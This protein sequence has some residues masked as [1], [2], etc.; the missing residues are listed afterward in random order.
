MYTAQAS[1]Y[2]LVKV[3]GLWYWCDS[4]KCRQLLLVNYLIEHW[5]KITWSAL[6][7]VLAVVLISFIIPEP[8][9]QNYVPVVSTQDSI[10]P[11]NEQTL[12]EEI[13][14]QGI[15]CEKEVLAQAKI[16]SLH[17]T[18]GLLSKTNNMF[19]MR[20]PGK[21]KTTAIGVY[22]QGKDSIIYG[23]PKELKKYLKLP[24]YAVYASWQDAV[25][26][27]KLWQ[28]FS[29]KTRSKYLDFLSSI[30]AEDSTYVMRVKQVA[31]KIDL[32]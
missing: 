9:N 4:L 11:L 14:K 12:F 22:L 29:F 21:R 20:Y 32:E 3:N 8:G 1:G 15:I 2:H 19:G 6:V 7:G 30:Y 24:T 26:D 25:A 10:V 17:L 27:Y 28:D 5:R 13:K 18:S 31:R 16:E 23:S